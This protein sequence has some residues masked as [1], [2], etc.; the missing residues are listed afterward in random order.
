[1]DPNLKVLLNY[2]YPLDNIEDYSH[3]VIILKQD[4]SKDLAL[5]KIKNPKT[6]L[7]TVK[8]SKKIPSVGDKVHAIGHPQSAIWTYTGIHKPNKRRF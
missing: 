3:D 8:V 5:L 4:Q 1:M 2:N 6:L 7:H